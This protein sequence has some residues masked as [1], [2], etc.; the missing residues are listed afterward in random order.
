MGHEFICVVEDVGSDVC[1]LKTGDVV[2]APFVWA[3]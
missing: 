1:G 3:R 2:V